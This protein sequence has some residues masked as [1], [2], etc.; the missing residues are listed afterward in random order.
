MQKILEF[1]CFA[2]G[3]KGARPLGDVCVRCR[4]EG[5]AGLE[6]LCQSE[7]EPLPGFPASECP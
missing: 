4:M 6:E 2:F 1:Q 7:D 3:V 5:C